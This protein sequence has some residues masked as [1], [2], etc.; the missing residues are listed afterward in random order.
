MRTR[1]TGELR[2]LTRLAVPLAAAHAGVQLMGFVDTAVVGRLGATELGAIGVANALFFFLSIFA[3]GV[4]MGIDPLVAQ[5]LGADNRLQAR[6]ILWQGIWLACATGIVVSF[7][8]YFSAA[9]L[10]LMKMPAA[11]I[12]QADSYLRIRAFGLVPLLIFFVLRGYLQARMM[13]RAIVFSMVIGNLF[14]LGAD[15]ILVFGGGILP[16]W[17]GPL[18]NLPA[19]GIEGAAIASVAGGALGAAILGVAVARI[20]LPLHDRSHRAFVRGVFLQAGRIGLP[21]GLHLSAEVAIF[22]LVALLAG[23]LG[24]QQL[25]A[26]QVTITLAAMTYTV[27][28]GIGTAGSVRVGRAIGAGDAVGARLG[29]YVAFAAGTGFMA[30]AAL[31]FVIMPARLASLVTDL[32]G[33]IT[34]AV[35]LLAVAALFQ[36]SDGIQAVGAGVLRGAGVTTYTFGA[37]LIGHWL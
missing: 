13:T 27:A 33:V 18:R 1:W 34:E 5:A 30:L 14:N 32:P 31:S 9:I 17:A 4:V 20:R 10:P 26:H 7:P 36:I 35:P 37:N 8:I 24:E 25:A 6:R 21:V 3:T 19:L 11:V 16:V 2:E 15:L 23:M 22:A 12:E 29:G 28:I